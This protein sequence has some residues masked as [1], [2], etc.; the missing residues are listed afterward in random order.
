MENLETERFGSFFERVE[1]ERKAIKIV[2][3][4]CQG[5]KLH[6]L[7]ECAINAWRD[8]GGDGAPI[9]ADRSEV[10]QILVALAA[11]ID[12]FADKSRVVFAGETVRL[13]ASDQLLAELRSASARLSLN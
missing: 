10:A 12:A 6:G 8:G 11:R 5:H 13:L 9:A 4:A 3:G 2:N 1:V 7:T